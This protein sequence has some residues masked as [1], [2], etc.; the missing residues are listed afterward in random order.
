MTRKSF[1]QFG[2]FQSA[3]VSTLIA[4][5]FLLEPLL[6]VPLLSA[7][8]GVIYKV[9]DS[10]GTYCHLKFPAITRST[11]FTDRPLLKDTSEG[12][13]RDFY[14][15]CDYDP[16]GPEEIRRQRAE[17]QRLRRRILSRD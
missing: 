10:T 2:N 3:N 14:G 9:S 17:Y 16:L 8:E 4:M 7:A 12:D 5:L 11:L 6:P 1:T 15:R 13:I